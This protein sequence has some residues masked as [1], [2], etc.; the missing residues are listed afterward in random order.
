MVRCSHCQQALLI[1][2]HCGGLP[3][4]VA[5]SAA[6][7]RDHQ[8]HR[9]CSHAHTELRLLIIHGQAWR[10]RGGAGKGGLRV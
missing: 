7:Q 5:C 4:L 8:R 1:Q 10:N 6:A 3:G 2:Q 9:A